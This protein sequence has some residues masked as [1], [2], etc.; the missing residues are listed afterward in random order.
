MSCGLGELIR[1]ERSWLPERRLGYAFNQN[2][3][4]GQGPGFHTLSY[5]S[6]LWGQPTSLESFYGPS[7][8][9]SSSEISRIP[10]WSPLAPK[11]S[12]QTSRAVDSPPAP[13][14]GSLLLRI[15]QRRS[16][17]LLEVKPRPLAAT[18]TTGFRSSL[19]FLPGPPP[20]QSADCTSVARVWSNTAHRGHGLR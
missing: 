5:I 4:L 13:T 8:S 19:H 2:L 15:P 6:L 18:L 17:P 3:P 7:M 20:S 10:G 11:D 14:E 9:L 1:K 12:I 16:H